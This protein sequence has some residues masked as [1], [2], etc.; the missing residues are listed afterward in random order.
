MKRKPVFLW[1]VLTV[2]VIVIVLSTFSGGQAKNEKISRFGEYQ[3]YSEMLYDST[4]RTS[5]YLTL[6]DGTRLAYD[7]FLPVKDGAVADEPLPTL[8]KYTPYGRCWTVL[9]KEGDNNLSGLGMPWY[10][11]P[12]LRFRAWVMP[13][14]SG[15][16]MDALNRTEWLGDMV[17]SGY[18]VIVVDRPG[19]GASFGKLA[20]D[21]SVVA[22]EAS[23]IID[24]IAAQ[25][26]S[27]GN[28]GMFGD[29]IQA[30]IQFQAA[31]TGNPHLKAILPATTW[32]D[33]Y[34]AVMYPGGVPNKAM[35]TLYSQLNLTF[36]KL[37]TP[38]DQDVDGSLLAQAR[39]ERGGVELAEKVMRIS[40]VPYRDIMTPDDQNFWVEHH[41]LYPLLDDINRSGTAVY[42]INGWY[43]L[44]ARDNFFTYAN[45]TVPKRLMV[46]PT[47]HSGIESP[48]D[49]V[50]FGAEAQRW[51]DYWL[52]GIDNG[53]M[54]EAPI[55]YYLQ[56]VG[57]EDAWHSTDVWPIENQ[58][59]T[60][61][62][63]DHED[64][65]KKVSVNNGSLQLT[66]PM[67]STAVDTYVVDYTTTSGKQPRWTGLAVPHEYPNM[68]ANDAKSLTYTT[69][70]L[71]APLVIVGHPIAHIWLSADVSD[72]DLVLYLEDVD[73]RGNSTYVSQGNLRASHRALSP[74]PFNNLGLPWHNHFQSD[75]QP[76]P[77][78]AP[79]ELV[80]DLLPTAYHFPVGHSLRISI[81]F[82][83][84]DS[85]D[86]PVLDP[87]PS[88][89]L[90]RDVAH[91]SFVEMPVFVGE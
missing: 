62:Y 10:Y 43:D 49:D 52:K 30:Q 15:K 20:H 32:M 40:E 59:S 83:D 86:T 33:N 75:L 79:I 45:L 18:A 28:V 74:A 57:Q 31:S 41:A 65:S 16:R 17:K 8:F 2:I 44:Y 24:W 47:D 71:E 14:G 38:V 69:P 50:D 56:G 72:L 11:D 39:A 80:F 77:P 61:Y 73:G 25:K 5:D 84:A 27:D 64:D 81:A 48:G 46:R 68:R 4:Q 60:R 19:T 55:H 63:F 58:R 37:A 88:V 26:W 67:Q 82:A 54:D 89:S 36:D 23:Q 3:G 91:P 76:I 29:S 21:P 35:A 9:D 22:Q 1:A 13:D 7:L 78:R 34:S 53:I 66:P 12:M 6:S 90:L 42:L 70:S 51:F 87:A 85:F